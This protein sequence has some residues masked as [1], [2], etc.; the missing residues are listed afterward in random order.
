MSEDKEHTFV[1]GIFGS[2][3]KERNLI[4]QALGA[5]DTKTD[6][7]IFE[8][9][10]ANLGYIFTALTP[11]DYPEKLKPFLQCLRISDIHILVVNLE[12]GLSAET[13]EIL[14]GMELMHGLFGTKALILVSGI[15]SKTDWKLPEI[16]KKITNILNTTKLKETEILELREKE[17]YGNLKKKIIEIGLNHLRMESREKSYLKILID[18]VFPVKGIGTVILGMVN[19][20]EVNTSQMVEIQGYEGPSKKA[21]VRSIQKHD[22]DFKHASKGDRV[23]LALKGNITPKD[24]GR[25]NIIATPGVFKQEREMKANVYISSFYKPKGGIIKPS[26]TLQFHGIAELKTSPMKLSEFDELI[27]GKMTAAWITFDRPLVH[28]GSGLKG[29]ITELNRFENKLRIVGWF[30]QYMQ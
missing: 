7:Q 21:I 22:R 30:A 26:D 18:H 15:S 14:V 9:H 4:G 24:I 29:L 19:S 11:V 13:G 6:I 12:S 23:G 5:P 28:D 16:K 27:P 25:D 3:Y 20:G 8:R 17:D 1:V 2:N 10:D